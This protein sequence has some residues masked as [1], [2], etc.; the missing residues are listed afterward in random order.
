MEDLVIIGG[1]VCGCSLLY[2]LSR[3]RVRAVLLEKENDVGTG[4]S[5]ANSGIIHAGYDPEPNTLM[6]KYNVSGNRLM[7]E[8]CAALDVPCKKTGSVVV[9][10]DNTDRRTI[11]KLYERGIANNVSGLKIIGQDELRRLNPRLS[12]KAVCALYAETAGVVSPWEFALAQAEA[13]VGGGAEVRLDTGVQAIRKEAGHFV[14]ETN[15]GNIDTRFVVNAAGVY[16][17]IIS[18]MIEPKHFTIHQKRGQYFLMDHDA[19]SLANTVIFQCPN[20]NGKGVLVAPTAHGNLIVGPDNETVK[21]ND[22]SNT[23]AGLAFVREMAR[24]SIPDINFSQSIRTFSGVRANSDMKDFLVAESKEAP[25]FFNIAGIK[26]P[27]LTAS[28]AI[29]LDMVRMLGEAG[30]SLEAN[31]GFVAA[32][33]VKRFKRMNTAERQQAIAENPRYAAI[34]CRCE[35]V[36]EGE[37]VDA[38]KRPL[39]PRSLDAVKRRCN[40]GMGRCQGG[41]CGPRVL[42]LIS[43]ERGIPVEEI[44]QDRGGMYIITGVT[45]APK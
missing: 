35:T 15:R 24:K 37:I 40:S 45:K 32:R 9:G 7:Y 29:A 4:A 14:V 33:R 36:T 30:L 31:P 5:K 43:R 8:L 21:N 28:P 26:S 44:P 13:A 39:P 12:K 10:F 17:D 2:A 34:V 25:G 20:E 19:S 41:F 18:Q 38:L 1:G 22:R 27:G 16:A 42:E 11:Q 3:Y 6:A 23:A